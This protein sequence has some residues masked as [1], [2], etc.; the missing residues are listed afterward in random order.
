[1]GYCQE[2]S[3]SWRTDCLALNNHH[4]AGV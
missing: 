3:C 4:P 2:E 1:V